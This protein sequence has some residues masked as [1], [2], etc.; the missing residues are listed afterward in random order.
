MKFNPRTIFLVIA[1][2][3]VLL[4]VTVGPSYQKKETL[5]KAA[6]ELPTEF[7]KE[8]L[9]TLNSLDHLLGKRD[10][11]VTIVEYSDLEC[12]YCHKAHPVVKQ[13]YADFGGKVAWVYRHLPLTSIHQNALPLA[14]A[15]ECVEKTKGPEAFWNFIDAIMAKTSPDKALSAVGLTKTQ[16]SA[17]V[18]DATTLARVNRD[19]MSA[20]QI[21]AQGTPFF[22]I[23]GPNGEQV[24]IPGMP[25]KAQM[26][27][28]ISRLL[29]EI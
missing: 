8:K 25:E 17:C 9:V 5:K 6:A 19:L 24:T 29:G 22:V 23:L 16:I 15:S 3:V 27:A 28:I 11:Q 10:A 18:S 7:P 14:L 12:P 2:V 1:A 21:G 26:S 20:E 13:V 4:L